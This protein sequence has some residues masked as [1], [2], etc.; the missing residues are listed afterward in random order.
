M[1]LPSGDQLYDLEFLLITKL[2]RTD[3]KKKKKTHTVQRSSI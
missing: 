3:V 2:L 1:V